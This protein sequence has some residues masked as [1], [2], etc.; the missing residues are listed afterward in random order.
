MA[1]TLRTLGAS[2]IGI[3]PLALGSW[4]TFERMSSD[5]GVAVMRAARDAGINFLDDARYNDETG[6]AP[7][8]TGYSEV[9]FGELFRARGW[10]RDETI[11]RNKLWWEFWP[12]QS[13]AAELDASLARMQFDY[14]DVIYANPPPDGLDLDDDGARRRRPRRFGQGAGVGDRELAR[15]S[16]SRCRRCDARWACRSR[17]PRSSLTAWCTDMGG[18]PPPMIGA[19]GCKEL[20]R[21][22]AAA[23]PPHV[24]AFNTAS[25]W[26]AGQFDD[27]PRPRPAPKRRG[28]RRRASLVVEVEPVGRRIGVDE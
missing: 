5:D 4:R 14:V 28:R 17:A 22:R 1:T 7:I 15:A 9:R 10:P 23:R 18:G 2:G 12:E 6:T 19:P 13:A 11:V 27:R 16:C 20:T 3:T 26:S 25:S 21:R 24:A 8:P